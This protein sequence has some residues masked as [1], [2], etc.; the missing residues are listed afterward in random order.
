MIKVGGSLLDFPGLP[1]RL[2]S[3][4]NSLATPSLLLAGGGRFADEVRRLDAIHH[5][6]IEL[7]HRIA[8]QS[9]SVSAALLSQWLSLPLA[10]TH[11]QAERFISEGASAVIE[12]GQ[13][14]GIETL[15]ASWTITSDSLAAW[16]AQKCRIQCLILAK[17]VDLPGSTKSFR[18]LAEQGYI[19][20]S[21]SDYSANL[22]QIEWVNLRS[23]HSVRQV[24][25]REH[26]FF[27]GRTPH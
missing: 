8:I 7:S 1:E 11:H 15:P 19:D 3:L 5:W 24:V 9:M 4:M 12:I 13:W 14:D 2:Q 17:S 10:Q 6:P 23:A 18:E 20:S 25:F 21:L 26:L 27:P 22:S 16:A